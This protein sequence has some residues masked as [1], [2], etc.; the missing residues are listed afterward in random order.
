MGGPQKLEI[1]EIVFYL[2]EVGLVVEDGLM[3]ILALDDEWM[4]YYQDKKG[5]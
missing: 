1:S 3:L 2:K 4:K 5:K